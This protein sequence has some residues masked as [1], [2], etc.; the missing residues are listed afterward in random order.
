MRHAGEMNNIPMVLEQTIS[1]S[2]VKLIQTVSDII[3]DISLGNPV[4]LIDQQ[5]QGFTLGLA[6]FEKRSIE[7]PMAESTVRGPRE[8]FTEVLSIN[9]S[10]LRRKIRSPEL[11]FKSMK[12][13]RYT[14]TQAMIGYIEGIADETLVKE[15]TR[16]LEKIDIDGVLESGYIEE[17]IE[18]NPW[19]PFPQVLNTERPDVVSAGLLEGRVVVLVD[20][21]PFALVAPTT[22]YS[23]L[24]AAEDYYQ[25]FWISTAV[26]WMRYLFFFF[27]CYCLQPTL[28]F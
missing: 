2:N 24:Q 25:R 8:G 13:G 22:F 9:I 16:R 14:K 4:I 20:G 10:L 6:K 23:L 11:K 3:E 18:D 28:Q 27:L 21:T 5:P 17:L 1:V 12:I 26:R 7:E 15:V 19:S